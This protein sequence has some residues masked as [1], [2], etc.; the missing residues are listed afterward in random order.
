VYSVLIVEDEKMER[1][2]LKSV[3]EKELAPDDSVYACESGVQAVSMARKYKPDIIFMDIF[4]PELDGIGAT[5]EIQKFLPDVCVCIISACSDFLYAQKAVSLHVFKY[6]LK[7]I[8]PAE[9]KAV[10]TQMMD[11]VDGRRQ[12]ESTAGSAG[13]AEKEQEPFIEESVKYIRKHFQERLTLQTVSSR[14]FMNPQYFSR[15]FKR[16]TGV[17]FTQFINNLRI[18]H[19]CRLL[20][21]TNYPAYR[22]AS[23]CGFTDASYFN[24]VFY[25]QMEMTPK[26]Y[27]RCA[28]E[29]HREKEE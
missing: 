26:E 12:R 24:R 9:F 5:E 2:F 10:L 11:Y 23:E 8:R 17:T 15:V 13:A 22:I 18:Q 28:Y 20:E 14:V 3:I 6:I 29:T 7:P 1:D 27:K 4:L 16:E 21:T 19:A 25:T